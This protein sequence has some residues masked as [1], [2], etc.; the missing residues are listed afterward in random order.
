MT[1]KIEIVFNIKIDC[2]GSNDQQT[3]N[4]VTIYYQELQEEEYQDWKGST[5]IQEAS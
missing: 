5:Y 1:N 3:N 4:N 2:M